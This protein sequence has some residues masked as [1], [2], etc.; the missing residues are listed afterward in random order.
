MDPKFECVD[1]A[2]MVMLYMTFVGLALGIGLS[3]FV[4]WIFWWLRQYLRCDRRK[5][6]SKQ[7][8]NQR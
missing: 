1:Q 3:V 8:D 2:R 4:T 7:G 5:L 6:N